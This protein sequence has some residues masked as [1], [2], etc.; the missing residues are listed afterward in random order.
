V[1]STQW[2]AQD[3]G[4]II[5]YSRASQGAIRLQQFE[6]LTINPTQGQRHEVEARRCIGLPRIGQLGG[7]EEDFMTYPAL[8]L[9]FKSWM[10]G[11]VA[12]L[13]ELQ[14]LMILS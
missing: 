5:R 13:N 7:P 9:H 3:I 12:R 8:L 14:Y 11:Y 1:T 2:H 6:L 4:I 10:P